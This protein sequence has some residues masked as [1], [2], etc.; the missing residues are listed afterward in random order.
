MPKSFFYP[1]PAIYR[2]FYSS[3]ALSLA[4]EL[5]ENRIQGEVLFWLDFGVDVNSIENGK[6]VLDHFLRG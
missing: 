2:E 6:T 5:D 3:E 4:H 1:S